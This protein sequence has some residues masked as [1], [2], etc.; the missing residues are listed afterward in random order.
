V[1]CLWGCWEGVLSWDCRAESC[2][3][4]VEGSSFSWS[5]GSWR[6]LIS[7]LW[8]RQRRLHLLSNDPAATPVTTC[9]YGRHDTI[10]TYDQM[11]EPPGRDVV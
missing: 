10:S 9:L 11:T 8:T 6:K 4:R 7:F 2:V 1:S 3:C 5:R